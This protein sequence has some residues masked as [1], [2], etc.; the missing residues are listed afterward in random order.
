MYGVSV[1]EEREG[2]ED[3][4]PGRSSGATTLLYLL[5]LSI[6]MVIDKRLAASFDPKGSPCTQ[7]GIRLQHPATNVSHHACQNGVFLAFFGPRGS[8][9]RLEIVQAFRVV[10]FVFR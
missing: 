7:E 2:E 10:D 3:Q 6:W 8:P 1:R 5:R 9:F 4:E